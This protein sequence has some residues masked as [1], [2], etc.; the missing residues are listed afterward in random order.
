MKLVRCARREKCVSGE[1]RHSIQR[2]RCLKQQRTFATGTIFL[3]LATGQA[4]QMLILTGM[5][6]QNPTS[7]GIPNVHL[8]S[9]H[10]HTNSKD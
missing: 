4:S 3:P 7:E 1:P 5:Q 9:T 10:E 8:H 6:M 2:M